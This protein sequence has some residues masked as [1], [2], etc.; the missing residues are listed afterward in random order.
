MSRMDRRAANRARKSRVA[1]ATLAVALALLLA[2]SLFKVGQILRTYG[3]GEEAYEE[4]AAAF[5]TALPTPSPA[6]DASDSP[7]GEAP[8]PA[9]AAPGFA[10]DFSAMQAVNPDACAWL[11]G[12][13]A[14]L[15]YPVVQ[16]EDNEYYLTHLLDGTRNAGG[17]LFVDARASADFS[18]RLTVIYGHN[19][20][21]GS[22]FGELDG[23]KDQAV[24]DAHPE[25]QLLT[26]GGNYRV[27]LLA[28]YVTDPSDAVY[29]GLST[30]EE[31]AAYVERAL[32][33]SAFRTDAAYAPGDRLVA[34]STCSYETADSTFLLLGRLVP[35]A[36]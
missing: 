7:A 23:Y 10:V 30:E 6:P 14:S 25:M 15:H 26:P 5:V 33:R 13:G 32:A 36:R 27:E 18:D 4:A 24:Y 1:L 12:E 21:N 20:N 11:Y 2:F 22:M 3:Q 28:G 35:E 16:G 19:M 17:C 31:I 29:G 9:E 34:L 8:D